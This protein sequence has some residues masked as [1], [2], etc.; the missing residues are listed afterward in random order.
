MKYINIFIISTLVLLTLGSFFNLQ[1]DPRSTGTKIAHSIIEGLNK[2]F[3]SKY[4]LEI[5][6]IGEENP[7]SDKYSRI[8]FHMS[9]PYI[10]SKDQGRSLLVACMQEA[11]QTFNSHPEFA[12][13]IENFPLTDENLFYVNTQQLGIPLPSICFRVLMSTLG[14]GIPSYNP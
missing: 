5:G 12:P 8:A 11:L 9:Y 7:R 4:G 6:G 1:C 2:T 10:L 13:Y 14:N 3:N